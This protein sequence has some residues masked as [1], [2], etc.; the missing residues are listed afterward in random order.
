MYI[1]FVEHSYNKIWKQFSED[2]VL[3]T[4]VIS[5]YYVISEIIIYF[6]VHHDI[7]VCGWRVQVESKCWQNGLADFNSFP[8]AMI[9]L[10]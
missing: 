6:F 8:L 10:W 7:C 2:N 9:Q 4:L 1:V 3:A 5:M